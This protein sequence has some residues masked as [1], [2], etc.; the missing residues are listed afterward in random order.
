MNATGFPAV[1]PYRVV[2][3]CDSSVGLECGFSKVMQ[4]VL[5]TVIINGKRD[6]AMQPVRAHSPWQWAWTGLS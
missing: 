2:L 6:R 5:A 1:P 3:D 4:L